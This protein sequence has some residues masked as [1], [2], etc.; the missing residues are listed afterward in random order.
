MKMVESKLITV[1]PHEKYEQ[2]LQKKPNG[3]GALHP[4][5]ISRTTQYQG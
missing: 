3:A 4:V 5:F 2:R 1:E